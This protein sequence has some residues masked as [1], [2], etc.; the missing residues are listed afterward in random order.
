LR[1]RAIGKKFNSTT[2]YT[3]AERT[4]KEITEIVR[5]LEQE[6]NTKPPTLQTILKLQ[7]LQ[8]YHESL[9]NG[10]SGFKKQFKDQIK[11]ACKSVL[12]SEKATALLKIDL[13]MVAEA[14]TEAGCTVLSLT[15]STPQPLV[16][17]VEAQPAN[18]TARNILDAKPPELLA[19]K[20]DEKDVKGSVCRLLNALT[21]DTENEIVGQV[22]KLAE[23]KGVAV[24]AY[25]LNALTDPAKE[26]NARKM[27]EALKE[28][29]LGKAT[30]DEI[31]ILAK[32]GVNSCWK[33]ENH[34]LAEHLLGKAI[35]EA[36]ATGNCLIY[37]AVYALRALIDSNKGKVA[38]TVLEKIQEKKIKGNETRSTVGEI[39]KEVLQLVTY[40]T[41]AQNKFAQRII[42]QLASEG[43][44]VTNGRA[45]KSREEEAEEKED[46]EE[47]QAGKLN[48]KKDGE[49]HLAETIKP[50]SKP[51]DDPKPVRRFRRTRAF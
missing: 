12:E 44:V 14:C 3:C 39:A 38:G 19:I 51:K 18:G 10:E 36:P 25:L 46:A 42:S 16:A 48:G 17:P 24:V 29:Q 6:I 13:G 43:I 1:I 50:P 32:F 30:L 34:Q 9:T 41:N 37:F 28:I 11:C 33:P 40:G 27:L 8:K 22:R 47:A 20:V 49:E 5:E 4:G 2:E 45:K 31:E 7:I 26:E 23:K 35:D 21:Q 15:R